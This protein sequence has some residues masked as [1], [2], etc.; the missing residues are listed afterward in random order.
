M[1]TRAVTGSVLVLVAIASA[2]F[3]KK[4]RFYDKGTIV[5][6]NSVECGFDEKDSAGVSAVLLGTDSGRKNTRQTL[7]P[8]YILRS[9]KLEYHIRPKEQKHPDLLP[10]GSEAEFRIV[11]D[12][13]ILRVP[14][15]DERE[16]QYFVTSMT[17]R[18]KQSNEAATS[19]STQK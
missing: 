17:S 10:V 19:A 18:D 4:P 14:E 12:H 9:D 7:C 11:K 8:E 6:M 16:R 13:M 1:R 5:K 3:A 15:K 2:G